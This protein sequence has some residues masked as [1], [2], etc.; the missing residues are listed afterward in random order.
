MDLAEPPLLFGV[1]VFRRRMFAHLGAAGELAHAQCGGVP[2]LVVA[3]PTGETPA[4]LPSA[5]ENT[6]N[7][8]E[9]ANM[10]EEPGRF[11]QNR[12]LLI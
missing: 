6:H 2:A 5:H 12:S 7:L 4:F 10:G 11:K 9:A 8:A 1:P 3:F